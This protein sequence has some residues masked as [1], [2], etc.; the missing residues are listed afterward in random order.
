MG[1]EHIHPLEPLAEFRNEHKFW[2]FAEKF[3]FLLLCLDDV[4]L[5]GWMLGRCP[6]S[7]RLALHYLFNIFLI[8]II[9]IIFFFYSRDLTSRIPAHTWSEFSLTSGLT[10]VVQEVAVRLPAARLPPFWKKF[11]RLPRPRLHFLPRQ[12]RHLNSASHFSQNEGYVSQTGSNWPLP[13][14]PHWKEQ[15]EEGGAGGCVTWPRRERLM[16]CDVFGK[17]IKKHALTAWRNGRRSGAEM[18]LVRLRCRRH[19]RGHSG[20]LVYPRSLLGP[21]RCLEKKL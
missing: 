11:L 12:Q 9:I 7:S 1:S 15:L 4:D 13:W 14:F 19:L 20:S 2:K 16:S 5:G 21:Y 8:H 10:A 6:V 3:F 18:W 17:A